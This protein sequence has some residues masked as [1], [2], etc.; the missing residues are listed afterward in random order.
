MEKYLRYI[1]SDI[2]G[3]EEISEIEPLG[4][5][6]SLYKNKELDLSFRVGDAIRKAENTDMFGFITAINPNGSVILIKDDISLTTDVELNFENK[7]KQVKPFAH[8]VTGYTYK[9]GNEE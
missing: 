8:Q 4:R 9:L 3:T 5:A 7:G 2:R 6:E 1:K